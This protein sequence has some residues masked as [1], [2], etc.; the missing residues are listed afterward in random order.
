[1][2]SKGDMMLLNFIKKSKKISGLIMAGILFSCNCAV[3]AEEYNDDM[4]MLGVFFSSNEDVRLACY[5][6]K[7]GIHMKEFFRSPDMLGR[8]P[9]L[10]YYNG[11]YYLC[12]VMPYDDER[13]FYIAKTKDFINWEKKP[14]NVIDKEINRKGHE[15]W[16]PD[17]FIDDDGS[18]YVYF[19]KN[20]KKHEFSIY[21]SKCNNIESGDF[22]SAQKIEFPVST[23]DVID[24]Q[25]RKIKGSYYLI[26]KNEKEYTDSFNKSPY[27]FKS[28]NPMEG[29][30]LV[31]QWPL[32]AIRGY[33]GFSF[34][35]HND[36]VYIYA[37]NY[38]RKF[39]GVR[40]SGFTVWQTND[41]EN[42][43]YYAE[44]VY[45]E[46]KRL[47]HG[48]VI[49]V[50]DEQQLNVLKQLGASASDEHPEEIMLEISLLEFSDSKAGGINDFAPGTHVR[51]L[52]PKDTHVV[53][54]NIV[55][56]Y[57]VPNVVFAFENQ[58]SKLTLEGEVILPDAENNYIYT[59]DLSNR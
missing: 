43:P 28:S 44:N 49:S 12:Y 11:N 24:A 6:T 36:K 50:Q 41:I 30:K 5:Y 3:Q 14:Y 13:T 59:F 42:G 9:S 15:L 27:L 8:D 21:V 4:G 57:G 31:S 25:V 32:R 40:E 18:A 55:N 53:I 22:Q 16:A 7:D 20:N 56:A 45:T 29:F 37:D 52:V 47:R 33:E 26:L 54:N 34:L 2:I 35:E 23:S 48:T 38:G 39:D 58:Q 51:Y 19:S 10:Q 46:K 17:L 1:M